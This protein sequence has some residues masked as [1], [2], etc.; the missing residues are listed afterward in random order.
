MENLIK[1]GICR[2]LCP[3][4]RRSFVPR[5]CADGC[6]QRL[7][8]TWFLCVSYAWF[9]V[10]FFLTLCLRGL[11]DKSFRASL[12]WPR[13]KSFRYSFLADV[14]C[15]FF[16]HC[17]GRIE[18]NE[19]TIY[20]ISQI[21]VQITLLVLYL[22]SVRLNN[23]TTDVRSQSRIKTCTSRV[24]NAREKLKVLSSKLGQGIGEGMPFKSL[25]ELS[26]Y[27][28]R[29]LRYKAS[30]F[31][32]RGMDYDLHSFPGNRRPSRNRVPRF[33]RNH[34]CPLVCSFG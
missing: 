19:L 27:L 26:R 22:K 33:S 14:N 9:L 3:W 29:L 25:F 34:V 1:L 6:W 20:R 18:L 31:S 28:N 7:I 10:F 2:V 8:V 24:K 15:F 23:F 21:F 16:L 17:D 11:V 5:I 4:W 32:R 12:L 13:E 30:K